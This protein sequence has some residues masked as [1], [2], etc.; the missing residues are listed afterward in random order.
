MLTT[1]GTFHTWTVGS[2]H[3]GGDTDSFAFLFLLY[4]RANISRE[5]HLEVGATGVG[6]FSFSGVGTVGQ[7]VQRQQDLEVDGLGETDAQRLRE[8]DL[9]CQHSAGR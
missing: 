1:S 5:V 7:I 3:L 6:G 8:A 4:R 9:G 2:T